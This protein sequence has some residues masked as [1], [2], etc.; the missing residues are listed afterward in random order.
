MTSYTPS[1]SEGLEL[2]EIPQVQYDLCHEA[3]AKKMQRTEPKSIVGV[4]QSYKDLVV[5][6]DFFQSQDL[7]MR[8][9]LQECMIVGSYKTHFLSQV[10]LTKVVCYQPSSLSFSPTC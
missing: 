10:E 6:K 3:D 1:H 5:L 2:A 4:H 7:S 8:K 9:C